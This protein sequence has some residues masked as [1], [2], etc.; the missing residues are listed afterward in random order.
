MSQII[1]ET[2]A[3]VINYQRGS[4]VYL[5]FGLRED[6]LSDSSYPSWVPDL[7]HEALD[8]A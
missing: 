2:I 3:F 6:R 5:P 1:L 4:L 7:S 8:S